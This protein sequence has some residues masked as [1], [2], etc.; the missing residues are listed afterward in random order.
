MLIHYPVAKGK[1]D[2]NLLRSLEPT[3]KE[4]LKKV[5]KWFHDYKNAA[6]D[7]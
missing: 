5:S 7:C 2:S 3:E 6:A 4:V 1:A